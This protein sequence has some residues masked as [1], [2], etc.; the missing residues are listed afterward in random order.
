MFERPFRGS[1][2][3]AAGSADPRPVAGARIPPAVR[4]H[5]RRRRRPGRPRAA[6]AAAT[7]WSSGAG[8]WP[9]TPRRRFSARRAGPRTR[10]PRSRCPRA[11][12]CDSPACACTVGS[13]ARRGTAVGGLGVTTRLR[14]AY[15]LARRTPSLVEAVVAVDALAVPEPPRSATPR[16]DPW[17]EQDPGLRS[18]PG[19]RSSPPTC[20]ACATGTSALVTA[21]ACPR[22]SRWPIRW[23]SRRWRPA[24]RLALVLHGLPP[25][26]SQFEL[27]A[28]PADLA[29]SSTSAIPSTGRHRVRRR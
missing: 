4:R 25:P 19:G 5:V 29:T 17:M 7:C 20:S 16:P 2:A 11:A 3:L 12:C 24:T 14:T 18:P 10:P 13:C 27:R 21:G 1:A 28:K 26:V 22:S 23:R 9:A 15:D 6:L 8:C